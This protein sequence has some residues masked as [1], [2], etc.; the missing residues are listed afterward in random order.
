MDNSVRL[1]NFRQTCSLQT[2]TG[3]RLM[4]L[5]AEKIGVT[6][7]DED[8]ELVLDFCRLAGGAVDELFEVDI[9]LKKSRCSG[10]N[11]QK[12]PQK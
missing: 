4:H 3:T 9:L 7:V 10:Q 5:V 2:S 1:R 11:F 12:W 6:A 8:D